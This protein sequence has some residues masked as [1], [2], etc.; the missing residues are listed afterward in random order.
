MDT[1]TT[2]ILKA[3]I[4]QTLFNILDRRWRDTRKAWKTKALNRFLLSNQFD[5]PTA[6]P[7]L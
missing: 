7:S 4:G 6:T 5:Y 1:Q 3:G 2:F